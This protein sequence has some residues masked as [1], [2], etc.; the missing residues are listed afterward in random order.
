MYCTLM[1]ERV[2][3]GPE[4]GREIGDG[5]YHGLRIPSQALTPD[6]DRIIQ[7][8]VRTIL[9]THSAVP[10]AEHLWKFVLAE[11]G[12]VLQVPRRAGDDPR[13]LPNNY[14]FTEAYDQICEGFARLGVVPPPPARQPVDVAAWNVAFDLDRT[15]QEM[16]KTWTG[17]FKDVLSALRL[18][19]PSEPVAYPGWVP[20]DQQMALLQTWINDRIADGTL[21]AAIRQKSRPS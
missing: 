7:D 14:L 1:S 21:L 11:D 10:H 3:N 18:H 9:P 20:D 19:D 12:S 15:I 16:R 2:F 4:Y 17:W 8:F 6:Q 5:A 13:D